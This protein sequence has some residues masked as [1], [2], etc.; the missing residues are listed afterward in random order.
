MKMPSSPD[1]FV[2]AMT[3]LAPV[4]SV[5]EVRLHLAAEPL[6]LW[7]QAERVFTGGRA[8]VPLPYWA[9]PWAGG[10]ALARYVLDHPEVVRGRSVLDVASGSGLVAIAAA[11]A[12]AAEV[13]ACDID[14]SAVAA[15]ALNAAANG[16]E[17][18]ARLD[19]PLGG[20]GAPFEVVL[21]ADAFYERDFAEQMTVFLLAAHGRG[22]RVLVGDPQR[23]YFPR[24]LFEQVLSYEVR[25]VPGLEVADVVRASVYRLR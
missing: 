19:D 8:D 14:A 25:T 21:A 15:T 20:D 3:A 4:P 17:V 10:Q 9:F 6:E 24:E 5:P 23:A 12:G 18:D 13:A 7:S 11:L 1:E 22:A 2:R 16:V